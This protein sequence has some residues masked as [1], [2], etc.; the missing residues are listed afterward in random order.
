[1]IVCNTLA[2]PNKHQPRV[3]RLKR[4]ESCFNIK[5]KIYSVAMKLNFFLPSTI[6]PSCLYHGSLEVVEG[7]TPMKFSNHRHKVN[8]CREFF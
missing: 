3:V 4:L 7:I 8:M 5:L 6:L 2:V 1:M